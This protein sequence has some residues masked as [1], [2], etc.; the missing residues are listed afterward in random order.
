M[1]IKKQYI[2]TEGSP[3]SVIND[4]VQYLSLEENQC[5]WILDYLK[6]HSYAVS[7]EE[8]FEIVR[9]DEPGAGLLVGGGSYYI[10]LKKTTLF[11]LI[12]LMPIALNIDNRLIAAAAAVINPSPNV[13]ARLDEATGEKCI[14]SELTRCKN[15]QSDAALLEKNKGCCICNK[16]IPYHCGYRKGDECQCAPRDAEDIMKELCLKGILKRKGRKYQLLL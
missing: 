1:E 11:L 9:G 16:E 4:F 3:A 10:S 13:I 14:V 12:K 2:H 5:K 15:K 8:R 7:G 6:D